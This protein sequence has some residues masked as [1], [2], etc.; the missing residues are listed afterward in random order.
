V[1]LSR[2]V[3]DRDREV[4]FRGK[5]QIAQGHPHEPALQ[6]VEVTDQDRR[7][8]EFRSQR[9]RLSRSWI[10]IMLPFAG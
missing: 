8:A 5:M 4:I 1:R 6:S 2:S 7:L 9:V 10:R 3:A